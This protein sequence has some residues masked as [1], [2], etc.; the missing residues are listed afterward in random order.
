MPL[1]FIDGAYSRAS[2][3]R[4]AFDGLSDALVREGHPRMVSRSGDREPQDQLDIWYQRMTL[5]PGNRRVYGTAWW[6]GK[7][8]YRIHPDAVGV[9]GASNHE[10]RRSHDLTYP[11]N[12]RNTAAHKRARALAKRWNITCEGMGFREDWHWTSWGPLG[13]IDSGGAP[14]GAQEEDEMSA[15]A[16]QQIQSI[17]DAIFKGGNSMKD[18]GASVSDSLGR[19]ADSVKPVNRGGKAVSVRQE[20]ADTKTIV[21]RLEASQA[22]LE[23]AL[24][25]LAAGQGVDPDAILKA[26]QQGVENA[27]RN[28]SFT[29]NIDG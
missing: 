14:A 3:T 29:A 2:G 6:Q 17:F 24:K 12:N 18:G 1:G 9:P 7:K 21:M 5:T 28:V 13:R 26:A 20:I 25:A 23:A 27:L 4:S 11:Y 15:K 8:W 19:I 22:G 16:E 10:K